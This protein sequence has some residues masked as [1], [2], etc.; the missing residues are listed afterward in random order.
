MPPLLRPR[1]RVYATSFYPRVE[2]ATRRNVALPM[3][4][5]T[6]TRRTS[7]VATASAHR[8][9]FRHVGTGT[10]GQFPP[11]GNLTVT[12]QKGERKDEETERCFT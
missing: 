2:I 5:H 12:C 9:K 3:N 1:Q 7:T 8:R 6:A 4:A 10:T 11:L